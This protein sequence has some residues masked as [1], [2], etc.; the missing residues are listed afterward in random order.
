MKFIQLPRD[1]FFLELLGKYMAISH[2]LCLLFSSYVALKHN[3]CTYE[4][5][6][7]YC[8][9][10]IALKLGVSVCTQ[11]TQQQLSMC[12][13]CYVLVLSKTKRLQ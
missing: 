2:F 5:T 4:T 3:I 11:T 1:F 8:S 12:F 7:L 13:S 6:A 9:V 10:T